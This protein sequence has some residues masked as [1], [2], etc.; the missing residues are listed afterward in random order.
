MNSEIFCIWGQS[1]SEEKLHSKS[2]CN[3]YYYYFM[4]THPLLFLPFTCRSCSFPL[5]IPVIKSFMLFAHS[6]RAR[7]LTPESTRVKRE[8]CICKQPRGP[9]TAMCKSDPLPFFH[10]HTLS[11]TS[12]RQRGDGG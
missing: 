7:T 12:D 3:Y 2:L 10:I 8:I 9:W 4:N 5:M 11:L 1:Q 6:E